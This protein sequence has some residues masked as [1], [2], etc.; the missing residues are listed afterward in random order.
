MQ[1]YESKNG[2]S[3]IQFDLAIKMHDDL[4]DRSSINFQ[5]NILLAA[6]FSDPRYRSLA[7]IK[8][9]NERDKALHSAQ[10]YI[11]RIFNKINQ[12]HQDETIQNYEDAPMRKKA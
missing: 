2:N 1:I 6:A 12:K 4:L 3:F 9:H 10:Y 11:K 7:F 5:N 8:D